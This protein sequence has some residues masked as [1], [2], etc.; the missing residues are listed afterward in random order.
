MADWDK[1]IASA[2]CRLAELQQCPPEPSDDMV[3]AVA[4]AATIERFK[5]G[6]HKEAEWVRDV[7]ARLQKAHDAMDAEDSKWKSLLREA[8]SDCYGRR[9]EYDG[10]WLQWL[11]SEPCSMR[12]AVLQLWAPLDRRCADTEVIK[13]IR[14]FREQI[15]PDVTE[16]WGPG[17]ILLMTSVLV[18]KL[19]VCRFP[20]YRHRAFRDAY[21]QSGYGSHRRGSD[22][23]E[24]YRHALGFLDKLIEEA[25][26]RE[27]PLLD[28]LDAGNIVHVLD[29][30]YRPTKPADDGP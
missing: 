14:T 25:R 22:V 5:I 30:G 7:A 1:Y 27:L 11:D 21:S 3:R 23:G 13:R 4:H 24:L 6:P 10:H 28:R 20:V 18:T 9:S 12:S 29:S 15:L 2:R 17:R 8:Y 26:K 19:G 16:S